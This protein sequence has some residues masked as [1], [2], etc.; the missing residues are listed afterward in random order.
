MLPSSTQFAFETSTALAPCFQTQHP[1]YFVFVSF[2]LLN[3]DSISFHFILILSLATRSKIKFPFQILPAK[4][5]VKVHSLKHL[6]RSMLEVSLLYTWPN[7]LSIRI[8]L[9]LS[10]I[11]LIFILSIRSHHKVPEEEDVKEDVVIFASS[12]HCSHILCKPF[13]TFSKVWD[14]RAT[15]NLNSDT[16]PCLSISSFTMYHFSTA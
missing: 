10:S 4:S 15:E 13:Q 5:F 12:Q 14:V 16:L 3:S 11:I 6:L 1:S 2:W 7:Q 9:F 8:Q